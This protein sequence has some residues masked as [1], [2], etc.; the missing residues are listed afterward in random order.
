M[1]LFRNTTDNTTK[2]DPLG[3]KK[4]LRNPEEPFLRKTGF[5]YIWDNYICH[6]KYRVYN[7]IYF[8]QQVKVAKFFKNEFQGAFAIRNNTLLLKYKAPLTQ[9]FKWFF[10]SM[11]FFEMSKFFIRSNFNF[12]SHMYDMS[13]VYL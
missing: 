2:I 1:S 8:P 12:Q 11:F 6:S 13:Y 4:K 5:R 10:Y 9:F 7:K 3:Q